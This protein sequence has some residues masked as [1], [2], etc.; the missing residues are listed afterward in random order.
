MFSDGIQGYIPY[1]GIN[2]G[3]KIIK[4]LERC[5]RVDEE[6]GEQLFSISNTSAFNKRQEIRVPISVSVP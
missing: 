6:P 2:Q 5:E 4:K 1:Q 3:G